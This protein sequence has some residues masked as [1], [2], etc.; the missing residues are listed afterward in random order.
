[1]ARASFSKGATSG[2]VVSAASDQA[3]G[4]DEAT[5][6]RSDTGEDVAELEAP[7]LT[8]GERTRL[9]I[10]DAARVVFRRKGYVNA[11][12]AEIAREAGRATGV[13]YSYFE[14]KAALLHALVAQYKDEAKR[15]K[16]D[17]DVELIAKRGYILQMFLERYRKNASVFAAVMQASMVDASFQ[18]HVRDLR[19]EGLDLFRRSIKELQHE[20]ICGP[21]DADLAAS[22]LLSMVHF[23]AWNWLYGGVDFPDREI[24]EEEVH[25]TL[26]HIINGAYLYPNFKP[27]V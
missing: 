5:G 23:S 27:G 6:L 1:M 4:E 8:K 19:L 16:H 12:I 7:S 17:G 9:A 26:L 18:S 15:W 13:F 14:N 10:L 20:G 21:V 25:A 24:S 2:D 3:A 11:E 22:A